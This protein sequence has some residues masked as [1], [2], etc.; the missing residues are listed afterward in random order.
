MP[1]PSRLVVGVAVAVAATVGLIW[2]PG[3][4]IGDRVT[5][6]AATSGRFAARAQGDLEEY[7]NFNGRQDSGSRVAVPPGSH[8]GG[9]N[10]QPDELAALKEENAVLRK[11][12]AAAKAERTQSPHVYAAPAPL[13]SNHLDGRS[14]PHHPV[15]LT[16]GRGPYP[17]DPLYLTEWNGLKVPREYDCDMFCVKGVPGCHECCGQKRWPAEDGELVRETPQPLRVAQ[18]TGCGTT[19]PWLGARPTAAACA[20]L[21]VSQP[22]ASGCSSTHF[23]WA[24]DGDE[25]CKCAPST[26][27][28][29]GNDAIPGAIAS[30]FSLTEMRPSPPPLPTESSVDEKLN[31]FFSLRH[32]EPHPTGYWGN[33]H[34][35]TEVPSRWFGCWLHWADMK[36]GNTLTSPQ[37]PFVDDEYNEQVAVYQSVLRSK[38]EFVVVEAGARWGTW[39]C[40]SV[41]FLKEKKPEMPYRLLTIEMSETNCDGIRRVK[42]RNNITGDLL[43]EGATSHNFRAWA[44]QVDHIDLLELDIQGAEGELVPEAMDVLND[45]VYRVIV[46]THSETIHSKLHLL[47]EEAGWLKIAVIGRNPNPNAVDTYLR[48]QDRDFAKYSF[49]N[50]PHPNFANWTE[51]IRSGAT[52]TVGGKGPVA[53]A[54]GELI[55]DNPKFVDASKMMSL[56]DTELKVDDLF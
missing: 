5:V 37:L 45:K 27:D 28:C 11:R 35:Y 30:L 21:V 48:P 12:I 50:A 49:P 38:G 24:E 20:A 44:A 16:V 1:G 33:H 40:R 36:S 29:V 53:N 14:Y 32:A 8:A 56:E 54:D 13:L 4:S 3:T 51:L 23:V 26:A 46:G 2:S 18:H 9:G 15:M 47:F 41:A 34:Y 6:P 10:S 19:A 7:P 39:G 55:Y 22:A 43:C 31:H 25:N 42:K 52:H 17:V